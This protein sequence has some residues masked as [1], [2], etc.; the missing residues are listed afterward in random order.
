MTEIRP[1]LLSI[2]NLSKRFGETVAVDDVSIDIQQN[3][4]F[5]LLGPSGLRQDHPPAQHGRIRAARQRDDHD[6]RHRRRAGGRPVRAASRA[7]AHQPDVPVLRAL[8]AHVRRRRTSPTASSAR[9]C[10]RPRSRTRVAGGPRDRRTDRQD[11]GPPRPAL[12]RPA[13]ARRAR[14]RDRQA[15]ATA[16]ARRAA[17]GTRPQGP[18]RD[19]ARAEAAAARGRAS[20][21]SSSPTTRR[22][23]CPWPTG[24]PSCT[25]A[26]CSRWTPPST[27]TTSRPTRSWP[28]SSAPATPS[29]ARARPREWR[30]RDSASS[31]GAQ[32]ILAPGTAAVLVVRPEDISLVA[33][34]EGRLAGTVLDT[35]FY[36]GRSTIAVE[37][38][39]HLR[40]HRARAP[41]HRGPT[42]PEVA[43]CRAGRRP[44]AQALTAPDD[45]AQHPDGRRP[46]RRRP[47]A[48]LDRPP[49]APDPAA[50]LA[51]G[52][53]C[54]VLVVGGGLTGL[55]AAIE[56]RASDPSAD[57]VLVEA[58]TIAFG[59]SGRNGG[60]FSESLTHGIAHGARALARRPR[61]RCCASAGRTCARSWPSPRARASTAG[62]RL[63]G[64][65]A[66]ATRPHHLDA[67]AAAHDAQRALRRGRRRCSTARRCSATWLAHLPRR[68][69]LPDRRRPPR[70]RRPH[71]GAAPTAR[72]APRRA[73]P[74]VD[75]G[76]ARCAVAAPASRWPPTPAASAPASVVLATNAYPPLLR[77]LR[78]CVMPIYDHVLVTE[79]LSAAAL[80][81]HR[82][83]R[84]AGAH[85]RRQPVPLLPAHARR[86]DPVGRVRRDLLLRQPHRRR[87]RAARL[88]PP[89]ARPSSSSR[90][91][92]SSRACGSPTAGR[93]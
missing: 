11:E 28:T 50:P 3:E 90:R 52:I 25:T 30:C 44:R 1:A 33:A 88:L 40:R 20:P 51:G 12:R 2:R 66:V 18:R 74:R 62:I 31:L 8:P 59:A 53:T 79:P 22:R 89:P 92:P 91:S 47:P 24:S 16:A 17:V 61:R 65:T 71:L 70:S 86:P 26:G 29:P 34:G 93:D 57:V 54:D 4:F 15:A 49:G 39:G 87:P 42:W 58:E 14:P 10:P 6:A 43:A 7:P 68:P 41:G 36:G 64:K 21:S 32:A 76:P 85:R 83:G 75:P 5:A 63:C 9:G 48:L 81:E 23:P 46:A 37:V 45:P 35:Q 56:A 60:F 77:R 80:G 69:A 19:A 72:Q 38:A 73:D 13:A 84:G 78:H 55:W 27:S 67:L 82:L